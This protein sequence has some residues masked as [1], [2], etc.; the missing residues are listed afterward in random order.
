MGA[1]VAVVLLAPACS[2]DGSDNAGSDSGDTASTSAG[3]PAV[4]EIVSEIEPSVVTIRT[5]S[6]VGSGIVYD[7]DGTIVT[8]A[9]VVVDESGDTPSTVE[10]RFADGSTSKAE[11]IA[12][13]AITDIGV[14]RSERGDLPAP[15]YDTSLPRVGEMVVVVGSPLGLS[16]TVT[17]GIVSGLHRT[18][19]ASETTPQG[20]FD[21]IQTDAAIS[22]GN[23]G[24]AVTNSDAEVIGLSTAYLPPSSGAVAIGFVTPASTV[25]DVADQLIAN[26]KADHAY[27]GIRPTEITPQ[28]ADRF[29][30]G[31]DS[32]LLVLDVTPGGPADRAGMRPG[33]IITSFAGVDIA[34]ELDLFGAIRDHD[35]G[36]EVE[37]V[38]QRDG[39]EAT[40]DLT[41]GDRG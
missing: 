28:L 25:T 23:S 20:L 7:S 11:V 31:T 8:S 17:A 9:H 6:G 1:A 4:P 34:T 13:D 33:D 19:P 26:G 40:L 27:V 37:V 5:G 10:V 30:L 21:L 2:D 39:D 41:L 35:P 18:M 22:P 3:L 16:E 38:V 29:D 14:I 24:G 32:G 12:T 15:T 36:D